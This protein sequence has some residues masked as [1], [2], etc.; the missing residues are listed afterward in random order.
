MSTAVERDVQE[1]EVEQVEAEIVETETEVEVESE[2]TETETEV[3]SD[4]V[5]KLPKAELAKLKEAVKKANKEAEKRRHLLKDYEAFGSPDDIATA[6]QKLSTV[7]D[8]EEAQK[9]TTALLEKERS[10][11]KSSME[12]D[13]AKLQETVEKYK[14]ALQQQLVDNKAL[15][16]LAEHKGIPD[17]LMPKIK[18]S[19]A[20]V[21]DD[22]G[23]FAIRVLDADG[24]PKINNKGEYASIEDLVLELKASKTYGR[25][26]EMDK[27]PSGGNLQGDKV[28]KSAKPQHNVK[29]ADMSEVQ[30]T[31]F[32][33]KHGFAAYKELK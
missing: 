22:N 27:V 14:S 19:I 11:V 30:R 13:L 7:P 21:E 1:N 33:K 25:A 29:K 4:E 6:F 20:T 5:V 17:L 24:E 26:F 3:E 9:A 32:I 8:Q 23:N 2:Q 16:V 15:Q 28:A 18:S 12:K 10:K 31:E